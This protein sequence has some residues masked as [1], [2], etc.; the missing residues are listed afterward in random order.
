MEVQVV[1]VEFAL[2][3]GQLIT[4]SLKEI[5]VVQFAITAV[6]VPIDL[7]DKILVFLFALG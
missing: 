5:L 4:F 1:E 3:H 7:L 2:M 6:Y